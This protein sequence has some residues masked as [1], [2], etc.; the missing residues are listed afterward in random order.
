MSL[1]KSVLW[2]NKLDEKIL[3]IR[4]K[5]CLVARDMLQRKELISEDSICI[6]VARLEAVNDVHICVHDLVRRPVM[7]FRLQDELEVLAIESA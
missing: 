7:R 4:N 3:Y 1:T 2:K 5:S 6:P